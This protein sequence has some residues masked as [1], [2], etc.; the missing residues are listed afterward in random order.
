LGQQ[1]VLSDL[2]LDRFDYRV[3]LVVAGFSMLHGESGLKSAE[4]LALS[5][6]ANLVFLQFIRF[7]GRILLCQSL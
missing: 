5:L 7:G 4:F 2:G 3:L 6:I 1:R